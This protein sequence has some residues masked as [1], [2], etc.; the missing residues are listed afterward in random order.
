M[1]K[2]EMVGAIV[3]AALLMTSCTKATVQSTPSPSAYPSRPASPP[4]HLRIDGALVAQTDPAA[5]DSSCTYGEFVPGRVAFVSKA[6][7]LSS[8]GVLRVVM[9]ITPSTGDQPAER[10]VLQG[11]MTPVRIEQYPSGASGA[12]LAAWSATSGTITVQS[13][14]DIGKKGQYGTISGAVDARLAESGGGRPL[15]LTGGW[16]CLTEP[17]VR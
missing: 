5:G 1:R 12:R 14:Q 15:H 17:P 10:P 8:G 9:E 7:P 13:A 3:V 6:M 16:G 2:R 11:G 4:T